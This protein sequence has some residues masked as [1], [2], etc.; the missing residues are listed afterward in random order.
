[1]TERANGSRHPGGRPRCAVDPHAVRRSRDEGGS[2]RQIAAQLGIGTATAMRLYDASCSGL[3]PSQNSAQTAVT[4]N[5]G[6]V[7]ERIDDTKEVLWPT[8]IARPS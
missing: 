5:G 6:N 7:P 4:N 3:S 8:K 2:W 1:M